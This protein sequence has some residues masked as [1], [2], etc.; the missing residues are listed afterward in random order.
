MN[1]ETFKHTYRKS[2]KQKDGNNPNNYSVNDNFFSSTL[3]SFSFALVCF[4][5][6]HII[7]SVARR[8]A[9]FIYEFKRKMVCLRLLSCI[10]S[11][12]IIYEM[13][14][15]IILAAIFIVIFRSRVY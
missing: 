9:S 2:N 10:L 5:Y 1:N 13:N 12:R 11:G 14:E 7:Y 3:L 8:C 6:L 15:N 4:F